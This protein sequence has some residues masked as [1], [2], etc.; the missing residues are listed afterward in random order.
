MAPFSV[1]MDAF[2]NVIV[3]V[4]TPLLI[5]ICLTICLRLSIFWRCC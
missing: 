4:K 2:I 1:S 5:V 3:I